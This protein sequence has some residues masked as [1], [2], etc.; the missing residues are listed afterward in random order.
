MQYFHFILLQAE[1]QNPLGGL[2]PIL[3]IM[4]VFYFFMIQPQMRKQKKAKQFLEQV[5]K[6]DKVVTTGGIHGKVIEMNE[7]TFII[8]CEGETRFKIEKSGISAEMSNPVE[9][10]KR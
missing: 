7:Q 8:E 4:V 3:L 5:R 9:A 10:K 1:S 2:L 6:G